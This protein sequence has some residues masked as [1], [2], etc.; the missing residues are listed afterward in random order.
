MAIVNARGVIDAGSAA[1]FA[2][3]LA[4]AVQAGATKVLVDLTQAGD[5][6][7]A[8]MNSLLAVRQRLVGR[9]GEVAVALPPRLERQFAT[10]GLDRRFLLAAD[11]AAAAQLLG[12][13]GVS[14]PEAEV[15]AL[16][17]RHARAA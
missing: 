15:G 5:V 6:T 3:E 13:V 16:A 10:L 11:R 7:T 1:P 9:G 2:R 8:A 4:S 17:P 12:L 14:S